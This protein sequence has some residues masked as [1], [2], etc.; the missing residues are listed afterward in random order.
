MLQLQSLFK[1]LQPELNC[2]RCQKLDCSRVS[3]IMALLS[4]DMF[5]EV[6]TKILSHLAKFNMSSKDLDDFFGGPAFLAWSRMGNLHG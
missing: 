4:Q 2:I 3:M 1:N 5:P 6:I